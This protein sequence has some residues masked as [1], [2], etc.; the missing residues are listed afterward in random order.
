[1]NVWHSFLI[2]SWVYVKPH[3]PNN[4][5][6][7]MLLSPCIY[8]SLADTGLE[9]IPVAS[10]TGH[11]SVGGPTQKD[12]QPFT[13]MDNLEPLINL[14][15]LTGFLPLSKNMQSTCRE[16]TQRKTSGLHRDG[17]FKPWTS[18]WG[19]STKAAPPRCQSYSW[20]SLNQANGY[21]A[22]LCW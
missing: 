9:P 1:M 8:L 18:L 20:L 21:I 6:A 10:W 7:I 17:G 4:K 3:P 11:Q 5:S 14:T 15:T 12:R 13:P 22:F 2:Y 19:K 16:P